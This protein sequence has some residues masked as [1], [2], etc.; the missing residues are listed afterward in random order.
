[1]DIQKKQEAFERVA[2]TIRKEMSGL[3]A[4]HSLVVMRLTVKSFCR[5]E[6]ADFDEFIK[7]AGLDEV[8]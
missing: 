1:M 6:G 8:L 5:N 2:A 7:W 4:L 3:T